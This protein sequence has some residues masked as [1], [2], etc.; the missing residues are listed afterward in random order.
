[1]AKNRPAPGT[2][3]TTIRSRG[4]SAPRISLKKSPSK[5]PA[6]RQKGKYPSN[7][8]GTRERLI[9]AAGAVFARRGYHDATIREICVAAG[10]NVAAVNYHFGD[11]DS[12]YLAVLRETHEAALA[13]YP[14]DLGV[15]AD[16][17]P[18][19]RLEAFVRSLLMRLLN[20][21]RPAWHAKLMAREMSDPSPA[22][23][24]LVEQSVRPMWH[25][26]T[27]ICRELQGTDASKRCVEACAASVVGQCLHY[28][29]AIA[30]MRLLAPGI[31]TDTRALA[32]HITRFSL[33]GIAATRQEKGRLC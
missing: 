2:T 7:P 8:P 20:E 21:G 12:L 25:R 30:V 31:S 15:A 16:D 33:G 14:P 3:R 9:E 5:T 27:G 26:L 29:H 32:A 24:M 28:K 1:M 23:G 11:K 18:Q 19:A 17:P 13:H 4:Q 6:V 22:L 10:A